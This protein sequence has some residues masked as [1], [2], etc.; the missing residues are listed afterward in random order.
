MGVDRDEKSTSYFYSITTSNI[1]D[2]YGAP[3]AETISQQ[4]FEEAEV[5]S[6]IVPRGQNTRKSCTRNNCVPFKQNKLQDSGCIGMLSEESLNLYLSFK[7]NKKG[8]Y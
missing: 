8:K 5:I 6:G 2:A 3:L 7:Y 4:E 1:S